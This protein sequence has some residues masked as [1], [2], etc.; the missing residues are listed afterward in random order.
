MIPGEG[1]GAQEKWHHRKFPLPVLETELGGSLASAPRDL[2]EAP[3][4]QQVGGVG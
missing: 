4:D 2:A 3:V 1:K